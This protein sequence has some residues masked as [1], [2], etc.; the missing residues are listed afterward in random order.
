MTRSFVIMTNENAPRTWEMA[1]T[2]A[3][4]VV[5][6]LRAREQMDDD[7]G[8]AVGLEDGAFADQR[9][10]QLAG[11]HEIAVVANRELAVDAVDDDRLRIRELALAGGRVAD[12]PDGELARQ[13]RQRL[14]VERL[15]DVPHR[16]A[17]TDL[18]SVGR[19]DPRALLS[20]MLQRVQPEVGEVRGLRVAEDPEDAALFAKLVEHGVPSVYGFKQS[21]RRDSKYVPD[22]A[23]PDAFGIRERLVDHLAPVDRDANTVAARRAR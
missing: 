13:R 2:I 4:S 16:L 22:R 19:G 7:L 18:D 20:A 11:V 15:V 12:V 10:A 6:G 9:V 5:S 21:A 14:G 8:V 23:R 3:A 17:V 1:S